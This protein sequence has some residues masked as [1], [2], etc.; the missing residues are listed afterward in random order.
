MDREKTQLL[1]EATLVAP[2]FHNLNMDARYSH[3]DRK[4]G[5]KKKKNL[6]AQTVVLF[7]V[8]RRHRYS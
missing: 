2:H 6:G 8:T 1:T 5:K 7:K 4:T 3:L